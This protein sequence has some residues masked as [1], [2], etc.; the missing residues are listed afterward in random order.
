MPRSVYHQSPGNPIQLSKLPPEPLELEFAYH[1]GTDNDDRPFALQVTQE[2][3]LA[4]AVTIFCCWLN[5]LIF[6]P[7]VL[8]L[9]FVMLLLLVGWNYVEARLDATH[10][11]MITIMI[12]IGVYHLIRLPLSIEIYVALVAAVYAAREIVRH[13]TFVAT[14][15][16]IP[17]ERAWEIREEVN[18]Q[19][20]ASSLL[21]L[22]L[23]LAV[24]TG[25]LVLEAS[26]FTA[27]GL[28]ATAFIYVSNPRDFFRNY[29]DAVTSWFS[30]NRQEQFL[31]GV[32]ASPAGPCLKRLKVTIV[33][34]LLISLVIFRIALMPL[35]IEMATK[36]G[37]LR[38][39][40]FVDIVAHVFVAFIF[41][42][43]AAAA[44]MAIFAIAVCIVG[45]PVFGRMAIP[46]PSFV[47]APDWKEIT[48][49]IRHSRN[50][51]E[52]ESLYIGRVSFD[53]SPLLVPKEIF[54]E[55][56]HFLG[57]SGSGKTA[58]GL[59][60]F[61]EQVLGGGNASVMVLDL[62]GDSQEL[63]QTIRCGAATAKEL[64]GNEIPIR[65]FSLRE[66][67]AT[68]GFNPFQLTCWQRLNNLQKT[69][70]LCGAL[71]LNYGTDYGEGYFT[72]ANAAVLYA[73]VN[74]FP[75]VSSFEQLAEKIGFV[76]SR[77]KAHGVD[78]KSRDAGNHVRMTVTR[79]ASVA[80]LNVSP[81]HTPSDSVLSHCMD[82]SR[83]FSHPE[84]HY[85]SLSATL[86]PGSS[87][88]VGR[89]ATYML[90]MAAT[91]TKRD[92]PVYLVIDE[93]QRIASRNLDYLLQ[94]ARSMGVAIILAN[95]SMQDLKRHDLITT[96]ETNCRFRQ[97]FA[98]SGWEDQDRLSR[99]SGETI[100]FLN[101]QSVSQS[102]NSRGSS[103]SSSRSQKQFIGPRLTKNDIKL[104]SDEDRKSIVL[105]NRGAG[106]AQY[107]GMP[108]IVESDFHISPEEYQ[109]RKSTPWPSGD[110]GTFVAHTWKRPQSP[111]S[112]RGRTQDSSPAITQE[113][114]SGPEE[115][116][117]QQTDPKPKSRKR[118]K[119]T[120]GPVPIQPR[121]EAA[122]KE[123]S[124]L[125]ERYLRENPIEPDENTP[126]DE[127]KG[128]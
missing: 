102:S 98:I 19:T 99:A 94:L 55:H 38:G 111:S 59:A 13:F 67:Q 28:L 30:Y 45:T 20:V 72:S 8:P 36:F 101:G 51:I 24:L 60:P 50:D 70:V 73:T 34:I 87:P 119:K 108:V 48:N 44:S 86:G 37:N 29:W 81:T 80:P 79:L 117:L 43:L 12:A 6:L 85:Y 57:D 21:L 18:W 63:L 33:A 14:V 22:P 52:R 104:V 61:I 78:E 96:L 89:L 97:W 118:R 68:H 74:N 39:N 124:D 106:Y 53:Q 17:L 122:A 15:S 47:P 115:K 58:R 91:M 49:R 71:G 95:Q 109:E 113:T 35:A 41:I 123:P 121:D 116:P 112:R 27:I 56:A 66:D 25:E 64:T 2:F 103:T 128:A 46:K 23:A 26:C 83:L 32:L 9:I 77:P 40:S 105:I 82:P 11:F 127:E 76:I 1:R 125:F 93:F 54:H 126:S 16:P 42:L 31:P 7:S 88:E 107:G 120:N 5:A 4:S 90:L 69:D 84:A 92:V 65:Y 110:E 114:I 100:D 75:N 10:S 62:K 3:F